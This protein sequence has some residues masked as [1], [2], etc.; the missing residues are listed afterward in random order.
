MTSRQDLIAQIQNTPVIPNSLA[1]WGLGQMGLLVKGPDALLAIDP[2][3]SDSV[4]EITQEQYGGLMSR[5]VPAPL[6]PQDLAV[7]DFIL[8]TH[9]HA[10]HLDGQTLGP[11]M[12]TSSK[13]RM[14]AS[15]W[16]LEALTGLGVNQERIIVPEA[17]QPMTLP[18]TAIR[19]TAVP[20]A[21]YEKEFDAQKGFRYLGFLLE[22]NGVTLYHAGDTVLYEGYHDTMR[23]LPTPDIAMLPMNGRDWFRE[24][25]LNLTGTLLPTEAVLTARELGW[26]VLIPGHNDMFM[27][28]SLPNAQIM[29]ALERLAPRQRFKFLQPGE[30]YYFVK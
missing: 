22:W 5:A 3:L 20:S 6:Q 11:A 17:L 8:A 15:G 24:N 21:H 13:T 19:L 27:P 23:D 18:G 7:A 9:E 2:Y 14:V 1:L 29:D 30:L 12:E 25:V 26:G 4:R 16:C 10:D 28:N